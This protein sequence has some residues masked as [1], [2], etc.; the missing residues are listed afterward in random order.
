MPTELRG[1]LLAQERGPKAAK[2]RVKAMQGPV[3]VQDQR[4]KEEG[5]AAHQ[6]LRIYM[7]KDSVFLSRNGNSVS[8]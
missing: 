1:L 3:G 2:D 5:K 6:V 7:W 4:E 8:T